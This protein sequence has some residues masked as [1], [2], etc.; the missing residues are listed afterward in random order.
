MNIFNYVETITLGWGS[1][2][3][4]LQR[5]SQIG[6]IINEKKVN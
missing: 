2:H 3:C 4:L 1:N 5:I 6:L